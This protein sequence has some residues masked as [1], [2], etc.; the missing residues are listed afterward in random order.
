MAEP[1]LTEEE[2][3]ELEEKLKNMS[4]EELREFQKKQCIFCQ[5]I[6]GG[7]PSKK[8]YEDDSVFAILDINPAS[9]GHLLLLPKE[10][11]A[12][13]PQIPQ[14]VLQK[15]F[16]AAKALSQT[17][18]KK[19]KSSGTSIFV[20]NGLAAGQK[21]QHFM[22]HIIPRK[23]GDGLIPMDEKVIDKEMLEKVRIAVE[24]K[25]NKF[26]GVKKEVVDVKGPAE[27]SKD[28]EEELENHH[29][30]TDDEEEDQEPE[31]LDS[32]DNEPVEEDDE[33]DT[34]KDDF[35]EE[36]E[37]DAEDETNNDREGANLDDIAKLFS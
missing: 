3:K 35:E 29:E 23:E 27:E 22:I 30:E 14:A 6:A 32:D 4:P 15:L 12:I 17:L 34:E 37:E 9:K 2:R 8:I 5:I 18:L 24:N 11:Y 10:H 33:D 13:M 25:L 1:Q 20:A 16:V 36:T 7:I 26:L 28:I 31:S 21:S 19:L